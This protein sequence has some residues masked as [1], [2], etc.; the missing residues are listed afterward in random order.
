MVTAEDL[1]DTEARPR[2]ADKIV[3]S[4]CRHRLLGSLVCS[5]LTPQRTL[6]DF[7]RPRDRCSEAAPTAAT[8]P[9]H[10]PPLVLPDPQ[11]KDVSW[12]D[13]TCATHLC[14]LSSPLSPSSLP[15]ASEPLLRDSTL[16]PTSLSHI[17]S[18]LF[19]QPEGEILGQEGRHIV[20]AAESCTTRF[21]RCAKSK[22]SKNNKEEPPGTRERC[23]RTRM[24]GVWQTGWSSWRGRLS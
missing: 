16:L 18:I 13:S 24:S 3:S 20:T 15:L 10:P 8:D 11:A 19:G 1:K 2:L 7:H 21:L 17:V 6:S 14:R 9:P 12:R 5:G 4:S 23:I 22:E